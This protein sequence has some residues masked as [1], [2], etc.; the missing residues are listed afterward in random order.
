MLGALVVITS[1]SIS[2]VL[3]IVGCSSKTA[4]RPPVPALIATTTALS[5]SPTAPVLGSPAVLTAKIS[6]SSG[7]GSPGGSVIFYVGT[8]ALG[9]ATLA[10][11]TAV[12]STS[13]LALGTQSVKAAYSGDT[14]YSG[15]TSAASNVS[16]MYV[17][18]IA[19]SA[20]DG[21]GDQSTA[22]LAVVVQ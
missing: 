5:V 11:G 18:D 9:T 19:V 12:L 4:T 16:I 21:A 15:S 3:G 6:A 1:L 2:G 7:S 22:Q 10:S 20:S 8:K 13:S 17:G 14:S